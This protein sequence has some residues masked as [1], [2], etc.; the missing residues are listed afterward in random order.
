MYRKHLA[1]KEKTHGPNVQRNTIFETDSDGDPVTDN[2]KNTPNNRDYHEF[3]R[4][5]PFTSY[6]ASGTSLTATRQRY[7]PSSW[8]SY[9]GKN[10]IYSI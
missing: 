5:E 1:L 4:S 9:N 3:N 7:S 6:S 8:N 10:F 2:K